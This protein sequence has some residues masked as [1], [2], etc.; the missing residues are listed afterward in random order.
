MT[1]AAATT[2][3]EFTTANV[4]NGDFVIFTTGDGVEL[5]AVV[6]ATHAGRYGTRHAI[7]LAEPAELGGMMTQEV[8]GDLFSAS[9]AYGVNIRLTDACRRFKR[10]L[11]VAAKRAERA[12]AGE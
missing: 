12:A 11:H 10:R 7:F 4:E 2:A 6:T 1:T 5:A 3:P 8:D 9:D